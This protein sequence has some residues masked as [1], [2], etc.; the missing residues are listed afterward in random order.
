MTEERHISSVEQTLE[1]LELTF[2]TLGREYYE[3]LGRTFTEAGFLRGVDGNGNDVPESVGTDYRQ[4]VR[5]DEGLQAFW[6]K[7]ASNFGLDPAMTEALQA[8]ADETEGVETIEYE[9]PI[10]EEE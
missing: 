10:I 7:S 8:I 4:L 1:T 5:W 9:F 6:I 3:S 2:Y